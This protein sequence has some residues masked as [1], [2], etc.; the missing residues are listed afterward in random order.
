MTARGIPLFAH[1]AAECA[2][3]PP[4]VANTMTRVLGRL[5]EAAVTIQQELAHAALHDR[6]GET[7]LPR[8][9][10]KDSHG[11]ERDHERR[12]SE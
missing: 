7:G 10:Q 12:A 8:N 3:L 4:A 6:L 2:T 1:L 9:V 11:R 5:A